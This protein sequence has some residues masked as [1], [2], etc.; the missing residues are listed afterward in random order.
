MPLSNHEVAYINAAVECEAD[1]TKD[2]LCETIGSLLSLGGMADKFAKVTEFAGV[3]VELG[4]MLIK[5]KEENK[6]QCII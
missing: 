1:K 5:N 3:A 4:C 2:M 6:D